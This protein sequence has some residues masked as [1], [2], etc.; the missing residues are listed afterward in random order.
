MISQDQ[1][2]FV[3]EHF[4]IF[5]HNWSFYEDVLGESCLLGDI[6][7]YCDGAG[8]YLPAFS[9]RSSGYEFTAGEIA[10]FVEQ[11]FQHF[12]QVQ[13]TRFIDVWGQFC[14]LPPVYRSQ[15]GRQYTLYVQTAYQEESFD[16]IFDL[17][18]FDQET[19]PSARKRL[20][21]L[22][23]KDIQTTIRKTRGFSYEHFA[24][25]ESWLHDHA[26]V[27]SSIHREF[28]YALRSYV[29]K[30][31]AF[32]C[33]ARSQNK[34]VG[35]SIISVIGHER[36]A[37]LNSFPSR[38]PGLRVGDAL[39]AEAIKFARQNGIRWIHY[40][41]SVNKSLLSTKESW[42]ATGRSS[43]FRESF[44]VLDNDKEA[45][46]TALKGRTLWRLRLSDLT[47]T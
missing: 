4:N 7:A 42:G 8:I 44:Y 28:L 24:I 6:L 12:S 21:A 11:A 37:I 35:L 2:N 25:I 3:A 38:I 27:V 29:N 31:E 14:D 47:A 17:L 33:E 26:S 18:V 15:D 32:F 1:A 5:E 39:F 34:L 41:Y 40:G 22:K 10:H 46:E 13:P 16:S 19:P 23:N 43:S 30:G 36:M 20:R 9:L 45:A